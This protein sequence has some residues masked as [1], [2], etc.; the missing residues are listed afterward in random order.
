MNYL[1]SPPL[2]KPFT[3]DE[4]KP[5]EWAQFFTRLVQ[6]FNTMQ[7]TG[8]TVQRPNPAPFIGF[9]YFDTTLGK[10]IWAATSTSWVDST[11]TPA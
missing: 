7:Q 10:P 9:M 4:G 1:P 5:P 8:T 2:R 6:L 11:G 3:D